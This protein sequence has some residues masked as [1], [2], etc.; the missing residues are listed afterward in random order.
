MVKGKHKYIINRSQYNMAPSE[1]S[2]P[3]TGSHGYANTPEE[4]DCDLKF[5]LIKLIEVFK[6]DINNSLKEI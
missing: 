4:Q 1:P 2:S 6:W 3:T 5:Q